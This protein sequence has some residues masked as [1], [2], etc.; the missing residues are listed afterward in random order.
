MST[1]AANATDTAATPPSRAAWNLLDVDG[2]AIRY[3]RFGHGTPLVYLHSS[4]GEAGALPVFDAL[5]AAGFEVI[6][7]ELPGFGQSAAEPVWQH[8]SDVV[9]TLRRILDLL[10]V[11]R[12]VLVGSSLGGWLAAE[13]AIWFPERV[14][15]LALLAPFGLRIDD[16]P[17]FQIFGA[18]NDDLLP[19][20][21]A[22]P[23]DLPTHLAPA[24]PDEDPFALPIHLY[25]ALAATAQIGWNPFLHDPRLV[26]RLGL[27][28]APTLVV[29]GERDGI[30]PAA[31][32]TA[33]AAA[34][35][36]AHLALLADCGHLPALEDPAEITQLLTA[37]A[38]PSGGAATS[39]ITPPAGSA[40]PAGSAPTSPS[41]S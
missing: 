7:P 6:A 11:P 27:I 36:G 21:L 32:T 2:I 38:H 13:L 20:L 29:R 12:A 8:I 40:S 30:L 5:A 24:L 19:R 4:V 3:V 16:A 17:I 23:A 25:R 15:A 34:I 18:E 41:G 9:F 33:Y 37:I 31:H 14:R 1:L 28:T 22:R 39:G 26:Q 35:P 10:D